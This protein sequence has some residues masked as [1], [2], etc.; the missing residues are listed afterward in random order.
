MFEEK[1]LID[2]IKSLTGY[3]T[4]LAIDA[5]INAV[6]EANDKTIKVFV[7]HI[8]IHVQHK[9]YIYANGYNELENPQ[10]LLTEIRIVC[11][12]SELVTVRTNVANAYKNF[13]P[14][15]FD[16][17]Y[18]SL[19]FMEAKLLSSTNNKINWSEYVGLVFPRFTH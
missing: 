18:S 1:L 7:G 5:A 15:P 14:F 9:E 11:P 12:R 2:R 6:T 4:Q 16:S 3:D 17:N 8:G 10:V 19:V 13:S